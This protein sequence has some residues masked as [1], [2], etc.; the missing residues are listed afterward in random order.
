MGLLTKALR[1][2]ATSGVA[3]PA[4]WLT[5]MLGGPATASGMQVNELTALKSTAVY[6]CIRILTEGV[7]SLP[8]NTYEELADGGK[9][10]AREHP[11]YSLL[12]D[13]A[14]PEMTSME[15]WETSVGHL[16]TWGNAYAEIQ[17][18]AGGRPI[19]LWPLRPDRMRVYRDPSTFRLVYHYSLPYGSIA[20]LDVADVL[21]IRSRSLDGIIGI[22][23]VQQA[24]EGVGL[25]MALEQY[26]GKLFANN[27]TP[28]GVLMS[29]KQLSEKARTNMRDSWESA[30]RGLTNAHRVAILEDDV[31]WQSV[32]LPPEQAQ[33]ILTRQFT[34]S[35]IA[36]IWRIPPHMLQ[37]LSRSTHN[38]IE[39][40]SLEYVIH[41]LRPYL[42]RGEQ[43]LKVD[44][45]GLKVPFYAKWLVEGILRG[46]IASRYNAY[47]VG[48]QWGWLSADDIRAAEDMN[49][50]P[51]GTG[52]IYLNPL[53]MAPAG[54]VSEPTIQGGPQDDPLED[55]ESTSDPAARMALREVLEEALGRVARR[56]AH[57]VLVAARKLDEGGFASW[58]V[59]DFMRRHGDFVAEQLRAPLNG[60][61]MLGEAV[62][63][64]GDFADQYRS[65]RADWLASLLPRGI[66]ALES[67]FR[68]WTA[69]MPAQLANTLMGGSN[70]TSQH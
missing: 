12:H 66:A 40:Q 14:N 3:Y 48:R 22:S 28:G 38:N 42:V 49:P 41:T 64:A 57:D 8:L 21:H 62:P 5:D 55:P 44:L 50:L 2:V 43:R 10:L 68:E 24:A 51:D 58:Y 30:H 31:T 46:D 17:R 34:L 4:A 63:S 60:L 15:F 27:S 19:A 1:S 59:T 56:E 67:E 20:I 45:F 33:F 6:A 23:P 9:R 7:S 13:L 39:Q 16:A 26:A 18:D 53:N 29:K 32:G 11:V 69:E 47:A 70:G 65:R 61:R 35:S 54:S 37:E 52:E 25:D 36:R